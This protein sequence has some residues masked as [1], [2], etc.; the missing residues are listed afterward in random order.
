MVNGAA[1]FISNGGELCHKV[2]AVN[3]AMTTSML[4][5]RN[6]FDCEIE[7]VATIKQLNCPKNNKNFMP[8]WVL[9]L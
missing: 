3:G 2:I 9:L 7:N 6:L 5:Q 8:I 4:L 1:I